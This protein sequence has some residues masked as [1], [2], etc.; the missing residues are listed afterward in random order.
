M[1]IHLVSDTQSQCP[2]A[3]LS[4]VRPRFTLSKEKTQSLSQLFIKQAPVI[5][6]NPCQTEK[7]YG[8][9]F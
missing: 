3:K 9:L 5:Y 6:P 8:S 2:G 4:K 1:S 7:A